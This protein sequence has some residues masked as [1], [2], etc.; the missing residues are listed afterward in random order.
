MD[1]ITAWS[2]EHNYFGGT[3]E[4]NERRTRIVIGLTAIMMV[5]E[6]VSGLLFG[7]MA[8]LADGWHM[9]SH[10]AALTIT[11]LGYAFARRNAS[12]P[13]FSFGTGKVGDLAGY[14]SALLLAFI[15]ILMAY[16]SVKRFFFPVDISFNEAITV[17]VLGLIVN[18]VSAFLLREENREHDHHLHV[19]DHN[20]R[21]AYFH[22]LADA[23]TSVLAI[24]ALS[25]GRFLG[26]SWMDPLMGIAGSAMIARW[27]YGLL[28]DSGRM[29]LDINP[30]TSLSRKIR[31]SIESDA[32]NNIADLHVWRIGPG[33]FASIISIITK[34]P[35]PPL[36]Y[37]NLIGHL[38][39]LSH[40]TV[41]INPQK[42][43]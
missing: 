11:A 30:S 43:R 13:Q 33:H 25:A 21:A 9:A 38:Q 19:A 17:A 6:I 1:D 7:S 32:D 31:E 18:V 39:E 4:A 34:N 3:Q 40:V 22:V 15:A 16:E 36:H 2:H 26:W 5:V 27:S 23:L 37:K 29:L 12:N 28:R 42:A 8:L 41:E 20:I 24:V 10:A 35:R 14:S